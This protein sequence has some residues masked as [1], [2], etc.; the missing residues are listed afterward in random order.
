MLNIAPC[1]DPEYTL[2]DVTHDPTAYYL[3]EGEA[4]GRWWGAHATALGLG[5]EV[6]PADLRDLFAGRHP[7]SGAYL[8]PARGSSPRSNDR[9]VRADLDTAAAAGELGLSVEGVRARLRAG[10]LAGERMPRGHWRIPAAAIDAYRSGRPQPRARGG[11]PIPAED[12]TYGLT[13]AARLAGVN[14]SYLR[15]LVGSGA[16]DVTVRE[17]GRAVQFLVGSKDQRGHW[18]VAAAEVQRFMDCRTA[19]SAVPAYDLTLRAPKSVSVLHA[20]GHL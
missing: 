16:P 19:P 7:R 17:S 4:P 13:E 6:D 5:G 11:L 14:V 12:G 9:Q 20:L 8:I 18:R 10:K 3:R 15:R 1:H 2:R